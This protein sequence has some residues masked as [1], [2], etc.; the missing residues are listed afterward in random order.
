MSEKMINEPAMSLK[1]DDPVW[2][3]MSNEVVNNETI[4][5]DYF[6][7]EQKGNVKDDTTY[8]VYSADRNAHY[9]LPSAHI[10]VQWRVTDSS[11]NP[12][13]APAEATALA[14][15]GWSL[16]KTARVSVEE[17]EVVHVDRPG[18]MNQLNTLVD[19]SNDTVKKYGPLGHKYIDSV[20]D[21]LTP[22]K[23]AIVGTNY[24]AGADLSAIPA[25]DFYPTGLYHEAQAQLTQ[26]NPG[27]LQRVRV[28]PNYD[29]SFKAKVDR[30]NG[31]Q[32]SR[33]PLSDISGMF[34][35]DR[36]FKG[37]K[38]AINLEKNNVAEAVFGADETCLLEITRVQLWIKRLKPSYLAKSR[39]GSQIAKNG[40]IKAS[41]NNRRLLSFTNQPNGSGDHTLS[42]SHKVN[43]PKRVIIAFQRND[44]LTDRR[45][46]PLQFDFHDKI[47]RLELRVNGMSVPNIPYNPASD[48]TQ[49]LLDIYQAGGKANDPEEAPIL[50]EELWKK[51]YNVFVFDL[52][53]QEG[54]A[55]ESRT[56]TTLDLNWTFSESLSPQ[57][58]TVHAAIDSQA[59]SLYDYSSGETKVIT[60]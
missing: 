34:A 15:N 17:K 45:L 54:D 52:E 20:S 53:N 55:F 19:E 58:V 44:R 9:H 21:E 38:I 32:W 18:I 57:L 31:L 42:L 51:V 12:L 10:S 26:A 24:L 8:D 4:G 16:F 37:S 49:I 41:Y 59:Q 40:Q 46:N 60:N 27:V 50:Y 14:S 5:A 25:T 43:K 23:V 33:L 29:P 6:R 13:E 35:Q 39:F 56:L 48:R 3:L 28:S 1:N 36:V 2:N 30:S 47:S 11:G 22:A 7:F